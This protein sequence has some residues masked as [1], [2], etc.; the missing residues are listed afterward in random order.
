MWEYGLKKTCHSDQKAPNHII[1]IIPC[2]GGGGTS[3]SGNLQIIIF[4]YFCGNPTRAAT[5]LPMLGHEILRAWLAEMPQWGGPGGRSNIRLKCWISTAKMWSFS[6]NYIQCDPSMNGSC[7]FMWRITVLTW[8]G[9]AGMFEYGLVC[10]KTPC[11]DENPRMGRWTQN[12]L[13][14]WK[15]LYPGTK[16]VCLCGCAQWNVS[17]NL[18][19]PER[20]DVM[21]C[22]RCLLEPSCCEIAS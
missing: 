13:A 22:H 10:V 5:P 14:S 20:C 1:P 3:I 9:V 11:V 7:M 15:H 19:T 6:K 18:R 4:R 21:P 17:V 12:R 2:H 8:R 16:G